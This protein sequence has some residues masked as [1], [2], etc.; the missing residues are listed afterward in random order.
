MEEKLTRLI[1]EFYVLENETNIL[2]PQR[3][4]DILINNCN[5]LTYQECW[6][7]IFKHTH[8]LKRNYKCFVVGVLALYEPGRVKDPL[9]MG[10]LGR[11]VLLFY[12]KSPWDEWEVLVEKTYNLFDKYS[13][14]FFKEILGDFDFSRLDLDDFY[15]DA[16][17]YDE[18]IC[19]PVFT[20]EKIHTIEYR[21][22]KELEIN[23][24]T[25]EYT[26]NKMQYKISIKICNEDC[27]IYH[28]YAYNKNYWITV[29][30]KL[31]CT[32][33]FSSHSIHKAI[34][35]VFNEFEDIQES[36]CKDALA[37]FLNPLFNRFSTTDLEILNNNNI[38]SMKDLMYRTTSER[39]RILTYAV[40]ND[41]YSMLAATIAFLDINLYKSFNIPYYRDISESEIRKF[42]KNTESIIL[43]YLLGLKN[44]NLDVKDYKITGYKDTVHHIWELG[45]NK[46]VGEEIDIYD[47][48]ISYLELMPLTV[49]NT[50]LFKI[51]YTNSSKKVCILVDETNIVLLLEPPTGDIEYV[52]EEIKFFNF[53]PI[54]KV[55]SKYD[56]LLEY[57][58]DNLRLDDYAILQP[59]G[60][61]NLKSLL[62]SRDHTRYVMLVDAYL[63]DNKSVL[64]IILALI[65]LKTS[66]PFDINSINIDETIFE[67]LKDLPLCYLL[68]IKSLEDFG[69]NIKI[70]KTRDE[71]ISYEYS[72]FHKFK[73][74]NIDTDIEN[75][76][77]LPTHIDGTCICRFDYKDDNTQVYI[78]ADGHKQT[79][80][81]SDKKQNT[82]DETK[83][84]SAEETHLF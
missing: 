16:D 15:I 71:H 75:F 73:S 51:H 84:T 4:G 56:K 66:L 14:E 33:R 34:Y 55:K 62:P 40:H 2:T 44:F 61:K 20:S 47:G 58:Y 30:D 37:E 17:E 10:V 43:S 52:S 3:L 77:K 83:E 25:I 7:L 69:K 29:V 35:N 26:P 27:T 1:K 32:G 18:D 46:P 6:D 39:Y 76:K 81:T 79:I 68:N 23:D 82:Q 31:A 5:Y 60:I 80:I 54:E 64:A 78:I 36:D 9:T 74:E 53:E 50:H 65:N 72:Q 57:L 48:N 49:P 59:Y 63:R 21:L 41:N 38:S 19:S 8:S 13:E 24:L 67:Y 70:Q 11:D 28:C 42:R 22:K 12:L 45:N